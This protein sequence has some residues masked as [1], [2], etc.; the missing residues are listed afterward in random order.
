MKTATMKTA[1]RKKTGTEVPCRFRDVTFTDK[2]AN[3]PITIARADLT[4][5]QAERFL[6]ARQITGRLLARPE[7]AQA[8]Q[9]AL[10][11]FGGDVEIAG[12]FDVSWFSCWPETYKATLKF[13]LFG[14]KPEVREHLTRFAHRAGLLTIDAVEDLDGGNP[15]GDE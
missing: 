10:P 4:L 15:T 11:G 8:T 9:G 14:V 12:V 6:C 13:A 1:E 3:V 7:G 2:V 5:E